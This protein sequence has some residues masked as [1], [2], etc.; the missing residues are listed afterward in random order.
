MLTESFLARIRLDGTQVDIKHLPLLLRYVAA[1]IPF[2]NIDIIEGTSQPL[3]LERTATKILQQQRG[4]LCYEINP[5]LAAVLIE[6]GLQI[7][8]ISAVIYDA[9]NEKFSKTGY[10][11]TLLLLEDHGERYLID[12]G[13]GNNVPLVA[14]PLDGTT[15]SST[16]GDYRVVGNELYMKR[17]YRDVQFIC[18][19]R[20]DTQPIE[21]PALRV[22]QQI[23]EQSEDSAFNKRPLLTKCTD[24]GTITLSG[25]D[26]T[27]MK[28]GEKT[29][30]TLTDKEKAVAKKTY[31]YQ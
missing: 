14:V 17:R 28:D 27:I 8:L 20:F 26:L 13:F 5:L 29:V 19:Y 4:G 15:V 10:T 16:N 25:N 18:A 31:F 23:I 12:A 30:A 9:M 24:N 21:W 22:S 7:Q 11:H 2:E 6:N 3:S 1:Y